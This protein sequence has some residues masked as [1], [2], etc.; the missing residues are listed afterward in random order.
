MAA[1]ENCISRNTWQAWWDRPEAPPSG[2]MLEAAARLWR[3]TPSGWLPESQM[4]NMVTLSQ[5]TSRAQQLA[6][7]RKQGDQG[8]SDYFAHI[9]MHNKMCTGSYANEKEWA[10]D[11]KKLDDLTWQREI[12]IHALRLIGGSYEERLKAK[13]AI[14]PLAAERW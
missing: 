14:K 12:K 3:N 11:W 8:G 5:R 1:K 6:G 7:T 9:D 10:R 4:W 13:P 2:K